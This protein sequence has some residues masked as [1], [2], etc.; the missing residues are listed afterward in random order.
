MYDGA[1]EV[2]EN[3]GVWRDN[4]VFGWSWVFAKGPTISSY[5]WMT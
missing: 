3:G 2:D 4:E 1:R 5:L